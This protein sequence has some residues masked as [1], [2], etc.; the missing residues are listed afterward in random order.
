MKWS[1]ERILVLTG[2]RSLRM[3]LLLTFGSFVLTLFLTFS[4][5]LISTF[6]FIDVAVPGSVRF[7]VWGWCYDSG[8]DCPNPP[9]IGYSF[10]SQVEGSL[11][12]ALVFYPIGERPVQSFATGIDLAADLLHLHHVSPIATILCLFS[13]LA[14]IPLLFGYPV[15]RFPFRAFSLL[16]FGSFVASCIAFVFMIG[17]CGTAARRFNAEGISVTFGPLV[18]SHLPV[19]STPAQRSCRPDRR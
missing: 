9:H 13:T 17:L 4:V 5:P 14:L 19:Q 16:A 8:G 6:Y 3:M 10:G 15:L 11:T 12:N 2:L 1:L 7:G 18:S